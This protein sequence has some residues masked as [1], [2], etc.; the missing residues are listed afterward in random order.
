M[1]ARITRSDVDAPE[2]V[3]AEA[4]DELGGYY[5]D[6]MPD[7][8]LLD[9]AH[10]LDREDGREVAAD[11][12]ELSDLEGVRF[13]ETE[14][15]VASPYVELVAA[16]ARDLA[17]FHARHAAR[18]DRHGDPRAVEAHRSSTVTLRRIARGLASMLGLA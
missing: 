13:T 2:D 16:A 5:L 3:W 1:T 18:A 9:R 12:S 10:V 17:L 7:R 4:V 11:L 15:R 8:D 14:V 6:G